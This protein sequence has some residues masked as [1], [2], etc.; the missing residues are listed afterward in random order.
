MLIKVNTHIR[1]QEIELAQ[2][3]QRD[4][5][6]AIQTSRIRLDAVRLIWKGPPDALL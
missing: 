4:L 3:Q 6:T 1:P 5:A 2:S